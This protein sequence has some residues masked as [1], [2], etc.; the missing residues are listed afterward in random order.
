MSNVE[1]TSMFDECDA[2][3]CM[4]LQYLDMI[5]FRTL[6]CCHCCW[7]WD[8]F[9]SSLIS[10]RA[11]SAIST[12]SPIDLKWDDGDDFSIGIAFILTPMTKSLDAK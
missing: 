3:N 8:A 2:F 5:S 9:S 7:N 4:N 6:D 11:I 1:I 10:W 12:D